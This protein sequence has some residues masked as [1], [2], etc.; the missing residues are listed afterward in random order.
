MVRVGILGF[1]H[2]HVGTYCARWREQFADDIMVVGGWEHDPDR[3][4][5]ARTNFQIDVTDSLEQLLARND[6]DAVVVAS[7]TSLH[8]DLAVAAADAGKAIILQK[9]M[10]LTLDDAD[11]IVEAVRRTGVPFTMAWQMRVDPQNLRMKQLVE[12][13]TLGRIVMLRRR[14]G[15]ATHV[16]PGF[17]KTW[18]VNPALNRGMWADDAAHPVDFI[19]WMLGEPASVIAE[20]DTLVNPQVPDDQGIAIFRYADG[21]FAEVCCSFTCVAGENTTEI[22]G[23]KGVVIQN[24]GDAPSCGVP[25]AAGAAGL[26]W[27][28]HSTGQ[29][30]ES[31]IA[32]PPGHGERIAGLA[33]PLLEFLQGKRPPIATAEEGRT[34]LKLTLACYDSSQRGERIR[35]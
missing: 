35:F 33:G 3:A 21:T 12:D 11:R 23:E 25:R 14:H 30:T 8:A 32:S 28:L 6:V 1:A 29:W 7:E 26:K 20:I 18:H 13:G 22:V 24:F 27:F 10:A 9:P 19:H 15:L 5:Q 16:W 34:S 4:K 17:D 2:G 31:D